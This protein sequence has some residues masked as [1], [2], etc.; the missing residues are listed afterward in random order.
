MDSDALET[1]EPAAAAVAGQYL[2]ESRH[3]K[4]DDNILV[5]AQELVCG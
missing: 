1:H 4:S 3:K 5:V 2:I